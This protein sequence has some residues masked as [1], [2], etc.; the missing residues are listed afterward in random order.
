MTTQATAGLH[1]VTALCSDPQKNLDFYVRVL[2]LRLVK[3]TVNFDDPSSYHLYYGDST[4]R[5]GT[6]MTF[7]AWPGARA[8]KFGKYSIGATAFA[9]PPGAL[10]WW[11]DELRQAGIAF[12]DA[13]PRFGEE[14]LRL[15][16]PDGMPV[17][18][19]E[20]VL[21]ATFIQSGHQSGAVLGRA[22]P[23]EYGIVGLHSATIVADDVEPTARVLTDMLGMENAGIAAED[24]VRTR[25]SVAGG[26]IGA[27]DIVRLPDAPPHH[28][29][30]GGIHHMAFRTPDAAEQV[31]QQAELARHGYR[32]SP[33]MD[34]TYFESIYFREPGGVLFEIAT[35]AP[36]F[37]VDEAVEELGQHLMLPPQFEKHREQ[38]AKSLPSLQLGG[39][40]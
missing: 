8:A 37:A 30:A 39:D 27:V 28:S 2:G 26:G 38:I 1:H 20:S 11:R 10:L 31:R 6:I 12:T 18:L 34:R 3:L 7:F 17:E 33:V 40:Q 9:V 14:C 32:V 21:A 16:D 35:D 25:F 5:P 36:G 15:S 24:P 19:V 22:H 29:G 23:E 4:G 13:G